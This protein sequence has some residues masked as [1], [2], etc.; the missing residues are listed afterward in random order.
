MIELAKEYQK[1]LE[2]VKRR[3]SAKDGGSVVKEIITQIGKPEA[4]TE[5]VRSDDGPSSYQH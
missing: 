1:K 4:L 5:E 3:Q 2:E